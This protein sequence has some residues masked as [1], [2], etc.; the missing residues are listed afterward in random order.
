MCKQIMTD[1]SLALRVF[2]LQRRAIKILAHIGY[3]ADCLRLK[4]IQ[5]GT[6]Y[7]AIKLFNKI[8]HNTR[9]IP[10]KYFKKKINIS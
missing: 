8:P 3:R 10:L 6:Q 7:Y 9:D 1:N 4:K 5:T 2:A